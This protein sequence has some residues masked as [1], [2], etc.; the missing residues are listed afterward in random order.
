MEQEQA[1]HPFAAVHPFLAHLVEVLLEEQRADLGL[2]HRA[3]VLRYDPNQ[4]AASAEQ[5]AACPA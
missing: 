5:A 1:E 4:Q 3:V 2:A